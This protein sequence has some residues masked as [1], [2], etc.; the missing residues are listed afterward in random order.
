MPY[1]SVNIKIDSIKLNIEDRLLEQNN[2]WASRI[3]EN[4]PDFFKQLSKG[5]N[6]NILWIGCSD[7]R[8]PPN[9]IAGLSQGDLFVHRNISNI[10]VHTDLNCLSVVQFGVE[11]LEVD[12]I[13][14]CG[15]YGCGGVKAAMEGRNNGLIDNWLQHI[16][17]IS[18]HRSHQL[19]GLT[20]EE[21]YRR[22]CELNVKEQVINMCNTAI[23]RKAWRNEANL[24]VHGLIYDL[25]TGL[26]NKL[27]MVINGPEVLERKL[28]TI[29]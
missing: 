14:I 29:A 1:I 19:E 9:Q 13:I 16:R 20:G 5:Q 4:D 15:H 8:V 6:P 17:D 24:T 28:Q 22:L 27:D 26:L 10:I 3:K 18:R 2:A 21:K 12:H 23:V 7:S 25:E 11:V